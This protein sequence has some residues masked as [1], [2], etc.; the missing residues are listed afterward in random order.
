MRNRSNNGE[1]HR[2][3][4]AAAGLLADGVPRSTVVSQ[5][6]QRFNVDRRTARRY[7][8]DGSTL[9]R[10]EIETPDLLAALAE[11]VERLRRLAWLAEG[12]GNYNA[13]VGAER[14]A[15][16]TLATVYRVDNAAAMAL[17][18]RTIATAELSER[19]RRKHRRTIAKP[20]DGCPF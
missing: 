9:L 17:S 11:S 8:A 12:N 5:L 20:P 18:G 3:V 10:A 1:I 19:Q 13:A 16:S 4:E 14:A 6:A 15:A 2:R 7:V